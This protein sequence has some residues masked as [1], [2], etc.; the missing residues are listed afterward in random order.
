MKL[1][2]PVLCAAVALTPLT[3]AAHHGWSGQDN[4]KV[5]ALEGT[6]QSVSYRNPH[7]QIEITAADKQRW[8]VTLAPIQRMQSRGLTE[9]D[10]KVG[11]T[12]RIE[13][14][15]SLDQGRREVKANAIT[16]AGKTTALR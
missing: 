3:A 2:F 16:I 10:L 13:G 1:A 9:A 4:A 11:Q 5:T 6:I 7:G 15:R 8:Q 12:V 14:H